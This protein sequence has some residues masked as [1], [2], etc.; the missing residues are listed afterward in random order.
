M[1]NYFKKFWFVWGLWSKLDF[2]KFNVFVL[3]LWSSIFRTLLLLEKNTSQNTLFIQKFHRSRGHFCRPVYRP[4]YRP[5]YW[6]ICRV[7]YRF[8]SW[9][10]YQWLKR[11]SCLPVY[12]PVHWSVEPSVYWPVCCSIDWVLCECVSAGL[13]NDFLLPFA[14]FNGRLATDLR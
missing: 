3:V 13:P 6:S 1:G 7:V 2:K 8:V 11:S 14:G 5:A 12:R 10:V 9:L 4:V